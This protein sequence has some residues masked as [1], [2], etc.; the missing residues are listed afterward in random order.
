MSVPKIIHQLWIGEKPIPINAMNSVKNMN[1]D[2]EYMFWCETT[3]KEKLNISRDYRRKINQHNE[4]WGKADL[5]RWFILEKYGGVF[6]DADMVSI[7]PLDDFLLNE[8]FFSWEN[9]KARP[10][11]CA[12][13]IQAYTPNHIIPQKA[14]EWILN[15]DIRSEKVNIPSWELV[16]PGLLSR[17]FHTLEDKSVVKVFPSYYFLPDHHT[18]I[19]YKGH[20]KVYMTHEWGSTRNNYNEI[21]VMK[22]PHHHTPPQKSIDITIPD[23]NKLIKEV[24]TGL[25]HLD[26]H[27]NINLKCEKD[28]TKYLKSMRNVRHSQSNIDNELIYYDENDEII[29]HLNLEEVEQELCKRHIKKDDVVLELGARYG[30]LSCLVN[31]MIDDKKN[32]YV[33]EPDSKVWS[34]LEDNMKIN[35][36][37]FNIIKGV[38]GK[39]KY[40]LD[41]HGYAMRTTTDSSYGTSQIDNYDIPDVEFNTLIADCEGYM[42]IFYNENKNFFNNINKIIMECDCPDICDYDKLLK[43]FNTLGFTIS[44]HIFKYGLH[45]YALEKKAYDKYEILDN[46]REVKNEIENI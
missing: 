9:E 15:N 22:I 16:G 13:S 19:K 20:G 41:G 21:N 34:A 2:Y 3:I 11:L 27:F 26:G 18:G 8:S 25:K 30:T 4:V 42:E 31:R 29:D 44:E 35:N 46:N 33:V 45:F 14:I 17:V 5:Y 39:E 12:T 36:C 38:I 24:M 37:D 23:D 1:P 6:V 10:N 32:H 7:H 43:E 40:K 28:I